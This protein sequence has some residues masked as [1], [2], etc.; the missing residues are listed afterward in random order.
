MIWKNDVGVMLH[1]WVNSFHGQAVIYGLSI[2][3]FIGSN[4]SFVSNRRSFEFGN[5][6]FRRTILTFYLGRSVRDGPVKTLLFFV[7][8]C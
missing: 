1:G 7:L 2:C 3:E 4:I 8:Y 6:D 5:C